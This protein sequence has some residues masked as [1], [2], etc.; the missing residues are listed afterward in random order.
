M[1]RP[2]GSPLG[3][4]TSPRLVRARLR[5]AEAARMRA[6]GASLASIAA[7]LGYAGK[8]GVAE[9]IR[10]AVA[11]ALAEAGREAI[12]LDL[13]RLDQLLVGVSKAAFQGDLQ[14]IDVAL[15]I[16]RQRQTLLGFQREQIERERRPTR[17]VTSDEPRNTLRGSRPPAKPLTPDGRLARGTPV[18]P[19]FYAPALSPTSPHRGRA[20]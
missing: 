1:S 19:A 12:E 8:Q 15:K 14:A 17:R 7:A 4:P 5:A 10:V 13:A 16:L 18:T 9:A 11:R 6:Q 20:S 3:S 2:G